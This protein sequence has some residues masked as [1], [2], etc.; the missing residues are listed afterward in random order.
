[1]NRFQK[2]LVYC[3]LAIYA[4]GVVTHELILARNISK[5]S[6]KIYQ[7]EQG[8]KALENRYRY[9]ENENKRIYDSKEKSRIPIKSN[10][11]EN[12]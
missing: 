12:K 6:T 7:L 5:L 10:S 3:G 2:V 11:L 8:Q 1:M 9:L 4:G